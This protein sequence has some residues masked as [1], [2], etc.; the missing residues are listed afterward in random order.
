MM[1][2]MNVDTPVRARALKTRLRGHLT[3]T[4]LN[5]QFASTL[6]L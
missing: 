1:T 4:F 3:R 5:P 2:Y 6:R